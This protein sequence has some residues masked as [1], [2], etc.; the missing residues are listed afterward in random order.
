MGLANDLNALSTP[1]I[2]TIVVAAV[3][4]ALAIVYGVFKKFTRMS[5]L[6]YQIPVLF[7]FTLLVRFV[8]SDNKWLAAGISVGGFLL[9]EGLVLGACAVARFA[10]RA[11]RNKAH[12][13]WRV[14]DRILGAFT[15]VFDLAVY[16]AVLAAFGFA[17]LP[18]VAP[19]AA[20]FAES[21]YAS[22]FWET[23]GSYAPDLLLILFLTLCVKAG[24]KLGLLR[25][26]WLVFAI[27]L[28]VAAI[29]GAAWFTLEVPFL[30]SFKNT[31]AQGLF[32]GLD[33]FFAQVF[34]FFIV[35]LLVFW[36]LFAVVVLLTVLV[37]L[38]M[39]RLNS[40]R[41]L[42][43][44]FGILL[45]VIFYVVAAAFVFGLQAGLEALVG[46]IDSLGEGT[47]SFLSGP[48]QSAA[49]IIRSIAEVLRAAPFT[50]VFYRFNPFIA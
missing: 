19:G 32:G 15:A 1:L 4:V 34:A 9:A 42:N 46:G 14:T 41:S 44:I 40:L 25:A 33:A 28:T 2:I 39:R 36:V 23:V 37:N 27:A 24:Y 12:V 45:A 31:V 8:P 43:V 5:W 10:I 7:A 18:A 13:F 38:G 29:V 30:V 47:L 21:F 16:A 20:S 17:L 48:I 49:E 3:L 6:A 11:R 35:W 22:A 26:I 50:G